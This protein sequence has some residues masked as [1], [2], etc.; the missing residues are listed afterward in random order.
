MWK[1]FF[2]WSIQKA[3]L[4]ITNKKKKLM[5]IVY[6][7]IQN[8]SSVSAKVSPKKEKK[9]IEL[10]NECIRDNSKQS[11]TINSKTNKRNNVSS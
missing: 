8:N 3:S 7:N 9:R 2:K 10:F 11:I 5:D 1:L 6:N 4:K